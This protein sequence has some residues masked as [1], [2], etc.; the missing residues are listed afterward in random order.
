MSAQRL[1]VS[2]AIT[3]VHSGMSSRVTRA[4]FAHSFPISLGQN[5]NQWL[6]CMVRRCWNFTL[7]ESKPRKKEIKKELSF[8]YRQ[9]PHLCTC[10]LSW[11]HLAPLVSIPSSWYP[12]SVLPLRACVLPRPCFQIIRPHHFP[13][14]LLSFDS[15][16]EKISQDDLLLKEKEISYKKGKNFFFLCGS[17]NATL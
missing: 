14:L 5:K 10:S 13:L 4:E 2:P 12:M 11:E 15:C 1:C 8:S 17:G 9:R 3:E 6:L 16:M 7:K